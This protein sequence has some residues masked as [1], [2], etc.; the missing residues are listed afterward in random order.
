MTK[1]ALVELWVPQTNGCCKPKAV[2]NGARRDRDRPNNA[3]RALRS[4]EQNHIVL[5]PGW[6]FF[7][8]APGDFKVLAKK[9]GAVCYEVVDHGANPFRSA[10]KGDPA[11]SYPWTTYVVG[12][13]LRR[14]IEGR[15][16]F[17]TA[18][19]INAN[20]QL[21]E[22]LTRQNRIGTLNGIGRALLLICGEVVCIEG[23][24]PS[25]VR[26]PRP[27]VK[28]LIGQPFGVIFNPAHTP[29]GPQA[30]RDRRRWLARRGCLITTANCWEHNRDGLN[31]ARTAHEVYCNERRLRPNHDVGDLYDDGYKIFFYDV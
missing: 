10:S 16:L 19:E 21:L 22:K 20:P 17:S 12:R 6:T 13:K 28:N 8:D 11:F 7:D 25:R 3:L 24:G 15:Q 4:I 26:G 31:G 9:Y 27:E 29:K 2:F 1:I 18:A 5:F 23:G 14:P 30:N